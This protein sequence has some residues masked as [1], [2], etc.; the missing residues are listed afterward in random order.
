MSDKLETQLEKRQQT[1]CFFSLHIIN[2]LTACKLLYMG[3]IPIP[4]FLG[5]S[6]AF[7]ELFEFFYV[8]LSRAVWVDG[9]V[10]LEVFSDFFDFVE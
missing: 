7:G 9:V 5:E 10:L 3:S 8:V 4:S 2:N 1:N 6:P